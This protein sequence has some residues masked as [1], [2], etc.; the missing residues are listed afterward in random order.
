MLLRLFKSKS[1]LLEIHRAA[2]GGDRLTECWFH[3]LL[4]ELALNRNS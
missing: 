3:S 2:P 4:F 1:Q